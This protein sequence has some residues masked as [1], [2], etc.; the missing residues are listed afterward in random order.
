MV[1]IKDKSESNERCMH[2]SLNPA[3]PFL[4]LVGTIAASNQETIVSNFTL[5]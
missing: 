3:D 4:A 5:N 1:Q 2:N